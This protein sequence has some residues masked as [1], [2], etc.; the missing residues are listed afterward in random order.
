M[1]NGK[2]LHKDGLNLNPDS[3]KALLELAKRK[4]L[5][6]WIKNPMLWL[7][8][9]L[10]EPACYFK[11]DLFKAYYSHDWDG[12]KN[13]IY[14]LWTRLGQSAYY[15]NIHQLDKVTNNYAL[16]SATGT[17]KTFFLARLVYWFLDCF[18]NSL[19]VTTAPSE[20]QLK[21]NLWAEIGRLMPQIK[22]AYPHAKKWQMRLVLDDSKTNNKL[23]DS[24][25]AVGFVTGTTANADSENKARGFHRK[26]MLIILE[27]ATGIPPS[28][29]NAFLNT[30][31]G[32]TN[33]IV[34]VGNPNNEHDTLHQFSTNP[35]T[36]A[37]RISGYDFPNVVL[38]K[39]IFGG[40]V[41]TSSIASRAEQYGKDSQFFKRMVRGISP[42][43]ASDALIQKSWFDGLRKPIG[44]I[45][46]DHT[47]P[48]LGVDVANSIA[49]DKAA[50]IYGTSNVVTHIQDFQCS[51]ATHLAYNI[52]YPVPYL[53]SKGYEIYGIPTAE[54]MGILD[55]DYIGVD[56]VGVGVA[57]INAFKDEGRE[58]TGLQGGQWEEVIPVHEVQVANELKE[59]PLYKFPNL[60]TQMFW[61]LREDIRQK[62]VF[63][64]LPE[65]DFKRL[66]KELTVIKYSTE[67][68]TIKLESKTKIKTRLMGESPNLADSAAYWN[69]SRKGYRVY[70]ALPAAILGG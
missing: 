66:V 54:S 51:N 7:R 38:K 50:C 44:S 40:A 27:E 8:D 36:F 46:L 52:L 30:A 28:I 64:D 1:S 5:E 49:G 63:F 57:T 29:L 55:S 58:V 70:D 18:P 68:N 56:A 16:E 67:G 25:H 45:E 11:W 15:G 13:P 9:R 22:K 37:Q 35:S 3:R 2:H 59:V 69:W 19:V 33:F 12:D 24:H 10:G 6:G 4:Q 21:V 32:T 47:Q 26:Y 60:R 62:N 23:E 17:S 48:A 20:S 31:T 39:E 41:S 34:A 14:N 65:E 42:T 61:E 43:E 53:S